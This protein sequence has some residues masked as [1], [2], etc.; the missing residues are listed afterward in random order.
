MSESP[1]R[2]A[3]P[4][5][6]RRRPTDEELER[7]AEISEADVDAAID[8]FNQHAPVEAKGLLDAEPIQGE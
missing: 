2:R 3:D 6:Q 8:A 1:A 7:A 4:R 5:L